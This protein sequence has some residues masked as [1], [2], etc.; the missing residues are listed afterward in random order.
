VRSAER[1]Q[2]LRLVFVL[3]R[4]PSDQSGS[5]MLKR[6][7]SSPF[8]LNFFGSSPHPSSSLR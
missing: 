4:K 7:H 5:D 6:H 8:V 3:L 1:T 2:T